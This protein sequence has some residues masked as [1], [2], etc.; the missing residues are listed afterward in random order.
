MPTAARTSRFRFPA[1][2][3]L[4]LAAAGCSVFR[5]DKP[6]PVVE[7]VR[8]PDS[9]TP[10]AAARDLADVM[11]TE[12]RLTPEQTGKVR[13]ILGGT[14]EQANAA[15][16]KF[17]PK[18]A[19]LLAELKRINSNSQNEL[20]LVMGPAKF[21]QLQTRGAQQKIAAEMQQRQK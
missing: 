5:R 2:L 10:P 20:R 4:L 8:T 16:A 12:L 13:T 11:A 18:S 21:K 1:L 19:Q 17:P 6:A 3:L 15:K 9:P 7:T 14:V